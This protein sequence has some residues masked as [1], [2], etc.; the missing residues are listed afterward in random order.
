M[1]SVF[2]EFRHYRKKTTVRILLS[3]TGDEI[4]ERGAFV[5]RLCFRSC[6]EEKPHSG[7][8]QVREVV[9]KEEPRAW[10]FE[11]K[12]KVDQNWVKMA[13]QEGYGPLEN[14]AQEKMGE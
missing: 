5:N 8:H 10:L 11:V 1:C 12:A 6:L 9:E 2:A 13:S 14:W 4:T 3:I 7:H